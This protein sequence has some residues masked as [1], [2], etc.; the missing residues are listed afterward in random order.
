M[1]DG[2]GVPWPNEA[3]IPDTD[4]LFMRVLGTDLDVDGLP[5]PR[6]FRNHVDQHGVAAMSTDWSKYARPRTPDSGHAAGRRRT[7]GSFN[8]G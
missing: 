7:T 4:F 2:V 6:V 8:S 1:V 3:P 5:E